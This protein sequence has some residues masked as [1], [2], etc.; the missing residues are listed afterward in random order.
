MKPLSLT[1]AEIDFMGLSIR[2][3]EWRYTHWY[4]WD[5]NTLKPNIDTNYGVEL[6]DHR[7]TT[8]TSFDDEAV[9]VASSNPDIVKQLDALLVEAFSKN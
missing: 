7:N 4:S 2:T 6:Y 9:N 5:G 1:T 8:G 3:P